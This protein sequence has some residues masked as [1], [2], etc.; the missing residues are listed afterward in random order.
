MNFHAH[1]YFT[2]AQ[3]GIA[4]ELRKSIQ[5]NLSLMLQKI[6]ILNPGPLGPHPLPTFEIHFS[7][8]TYP[9]VIEFLK[10]HRSG[11]SVLIHQDTGDD[12]EDHSK[13]I[14]WLGDPVTLDFD[15]FEKIKTHPELRINKN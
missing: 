1:I 13:N 9:R 15:F 3:R 12:I 2:Q 7:G 5:E 11:L 10:N 4:N 6:S 8:E 14:Q